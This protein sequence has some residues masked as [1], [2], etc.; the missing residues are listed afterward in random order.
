MTDA[1]AAAPSTQQQPKWQLAAA[2]GD[3][4]NNDENENDGGCDSSWDARTQRMLAQLGQA[5]RPR[6]FER[7][8]RLPS[9]TREATRQRRS[10]PLARLAAATKLNR[11]GKMNSTNSPMDSTN[12]PTDTL[13]PRYGAGSG[14]RKPKRCEKATATVSR[15]RSLGMAAVGVMSTEIGRASAAGCWQL[16]Y[17]AMCTLADTAEVQMVCGA[18]F[19]VLVWEASSRKFSSVDKPHGARR[20][21]PRHRM[22]VA[23]A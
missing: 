15:K 16:G 3:D 4:A 23:T 2:P 18:L 13:S 6:D 20:H 1:G 11:R 5:P 14:E 19:T 7:R 9:A 8:A 22:A 12:S 21:A 10:A 17:E